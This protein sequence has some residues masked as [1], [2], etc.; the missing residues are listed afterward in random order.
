[1]L[2]FILGAP[3]SGKTEEIIKRIKTDLE[4][5]RRVLLLV[6][7]QEAVSVERRIISSQNASDS[8]FLLEV[9]NFGRLSNIVF[10]EKGGICY[11]Y[12]DRGGQ[13]VMMY[14]ALNELSDTLST[15]KTGDSTDIGLVS[16]LIGLYSQLT[17][18]RV[19]PLKLEDSVVSLP[20][21]L[22][23]RGE[24]IATIYTRY[25]ELIHDGFDSARDD[26]TKV[27]N[28]IRS[29]KL[30]SD[31]SIYID[32]FSGFTPAELEVVEALISVRSDV[33]LSLCIDT[34]R[35]GE[36]F[37]NLYD[38][39]G[40]M[41]DC[42]ERYSVE[43]S[44][45][46]C[47]FLPKNKE[48]E[49]LARHLF[50]SEANEKYEGKT[51]HITLTEAP[52][53]Y[54]ECEL[55][56]ADIVAKVKKG[57][58]YRDITIVA[59]NATDYFGI[60]D[61]MLARHN[62]PCR[63]SLSRDVLQSPCVKFI[64]SAL[65][66][67][68]YNWRLADVITYLKSGLAGITDEEC[69]IL[70]EYAS[71]WA[72]SG[73]VWTIDEEWSMNPCGYSS[74]IT[75]RE[76]ALLDK[77]NRI[78]KRITEPLTALSLSLKSDRSMENAAE[79]IYDFLCD[80]VDADSLAGEEIA[81]WNAVISA[82]EQLSLCGG[83]EK[84]GNIEDL[85]RLI[86][87]ICSQ[88][89]FSMLPASIDEI[90]VVNIGSLRSVEAKRIY[91][92]GANE[93]SYPCDFKENNI[94]DDRM[95][96]ALC[97]AG[98]TLPNDPDELWR[99]QNWLFYKTLLSADESVMITRA[100][101]S[102]DGSERVISPSLSD[103]KRL[104]PDLSV[105]GYEDYSV[106]ELVYDKASA[107]DRISD[108]DC[109]EAIRSA[110]AQDEVFKDAVL[111]YD[112]PIS[113]DRC[114]VT[115]KQNL[116][117]LKGDMPM[118]QT[119]LESFVKCKFAYQLEYNLRLNEQHKVNYDARDVGNFIHKILEDYLRAS[120]DKKLD[121]KE[122]KE[123]VDSLVDRYISDTC[124]SMTFVSKRMLAMFNKLRRN[125]HLFVKSLSQEFENSDFIPKFFEMTVNAK[126]GSDLPPVRIELSDGSYVYINGQIDRVD[127]FERDGKVYFRVVDYKTGKKEFALKDLE[128]GINLQ[129]FLYLFA[130][131][132][133]KE[134]FLEL[135]ECSGELVPCATLYYL[136]RI[137][138]AT[139]QLPKSKE[140]LEDDVVSRIE[141][142][143]AVLDDED[144]FDSISHRRDMT[145]F[146][147]KTD[148][149]K[150]KGQFF[151][152]ESLYELESTINNVVKNIAE[153][154]KRGEADAIPNDKLDACRYCR[155]K[156]ICRRQ[157]EGGECDE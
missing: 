95:R 126:E 87:L 53:I 10:R 121:D 67:I 58:R 20:D 50:D 117:R 96:S 127:A 156:N 139:H 105:R 149:V 9:A 17:D 22:R 103:I 99:E 59:G 79:A 52:D 90:N 16:S 128:D 33:T 94:I 145:V 107:F 61:V 35:D 34:E 3:K 30:F 71:T 118:S 140:E 72:L 125:A 12:I 132:E 6:P 89:S 80:C 137:N 116:D 157:D 135:L 21:T 129:M 88:I 63:F 123:L 122:K 81:S 40:Y 49:H 113:T 56:C 1:M 124:A 51:E 14:R 98:L 74:R 54:S 104:F 97:E 144:V 70:E 37:G 39:K 100:S 2:S 154:I 26:L 147:T 69:D 27:A 142:K 23:S 41:T 60:L 76:I 65:N 84:L 66:I 48:F 19:T 5:K 68:I 11:N 82:L 42:A 152:L 110:L 141:R 18:Y 32:S 43:L 133:N 83:S 31:T 101:A 106:Y 36:I 91:I 57:M 47:E 93:G 138:S 77:I 153:A 114:A 151:T 146:P 73:S 136:A 111:A 155:M 44:E 92:I 130:I 108:D 112:V 15:Y 78:R 13:A 64:I 38:I 150:K 119:K 45:H 109:G 55:I 134:R 102:L 4:Q 86:R 7:E 62:I 29:E 115:S 120:M 24:D 25:D 75:E 148:L 85:K 28:I 46:H 8:L 143:G 131:M